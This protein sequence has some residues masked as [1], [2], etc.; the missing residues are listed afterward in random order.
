MPEDVRRFARRR[1]WFLM[2]GCESSGRRVHGRGVRGKF[3]LVIDGSRPDEDVRRAIAHELAH[4]VLFNSGIVD[5][6]G[7]SAEWKEEQVAVLIS[8]T[9]KTL[10]GGR[11][12]SVD[13]WTR[14]LKNEIVA[15]GIMV[16]AAIPEEFD[17][18]RTIQ[19]VLSGYNKAL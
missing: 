13:E 10:G 3:P 19:M 7:A 16:S 14:N 12:I 15:E 5:H 4:V 11:V 18:L 9:R 17:L 2:C 1:C 8:S 6:E